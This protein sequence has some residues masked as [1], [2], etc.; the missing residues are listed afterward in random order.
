MTKIVDVHHFDNYVQQKVRE[1]YN[2][3]DFNGN[4]ETEFKKWVEFLKELTRHLPLNQKNKIFEMMKQ[5]YQYREYTLIPN[6][7]CGVATLFQMVISKLQHYYRTDKEK[8][9][10]MWGYFV[11]FYS[12]SLS[13]HCVEGVSNR[14]FF[15][16]QLSND[17][18]K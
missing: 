16:L 8:F 11:E 12:E 1:D 18:L 7:E 2:K 13:T 15:I 4:F 10:I 5:L 3:Y 17:Y 9:D 6:T 14:A